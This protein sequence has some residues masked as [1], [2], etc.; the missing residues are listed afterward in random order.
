MN[1]ACG[2][3][4]SYATQVSIFNKMSDYAMIKVVQVHMFM[5]KMIT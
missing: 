5:D 4:G 3:Y 2:V 1:T